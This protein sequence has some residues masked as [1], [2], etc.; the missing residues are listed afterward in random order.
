MK[1][2]CF[3]LYIILAFSKDYAY[4][5]EEGMPQLNSEFWIAQIFWLALIFSILYIL[6]WKVFLPRITDVIENRK[7]K[8]VNDL[9]EIEKIK[10]TAEK[11]LEEYNRIIENSK[12]EAKKIIQDSKKK[13]DTD[14]ENK[15]N[16]FTEEIEQEL[17]NIELE[18]KN[19]KKSSFVNINKIATEVSIDVI[20][21]VMETN[22]NMS[23]VSAIVDDISK[24]KIGTNL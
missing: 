2:F 17:K 6:T 22:P 11:K 3:A 4:G 9:S 19:F 12:K 15:K 1:K 21:Q 10:E 5:A 24:K 7:L 23:S 14:L 20:K 13:L 16:K 8:I 18:I